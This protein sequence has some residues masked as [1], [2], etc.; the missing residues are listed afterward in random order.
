MGN[1]VGRGHR[2]KCCHGNQIDWQGRLIRK[3][4]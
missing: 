2:V 1:D 4:E 3:E